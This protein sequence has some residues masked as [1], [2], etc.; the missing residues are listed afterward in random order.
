MIIGCLKFTAQQD[1]GRNAPSGRSKRLG[2]PEILRQVGR[3]YYQPRLLGFARKPLV[4]PVDKS[5]L[6]QGHPVVWM[7]SD[8]GY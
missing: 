3:D 8:E 4:V 7:R 1:C 6:Q 2:E 5:L